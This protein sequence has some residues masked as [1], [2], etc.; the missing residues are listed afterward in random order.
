[1]NLHNVHFCTLSM[2]LREMAAHIKPT[3][4]SAVRLAVPAIALSLTAACLYGA[5]P[6]LGN[7]NAAR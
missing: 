6:A 1:M 2:T 7:W 3:A 5:K 4:N